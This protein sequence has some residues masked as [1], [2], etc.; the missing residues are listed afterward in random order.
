MKTKSNSIDGLLELN[1]DGND[2]EIDIVYIKYGT[3]I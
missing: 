1:N 3:I 2:D